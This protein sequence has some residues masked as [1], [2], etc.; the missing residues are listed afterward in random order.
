MLSNTES[1]QAVWHS[2]LNRLQ[3]GFYEA[4]SLNL[5]NGVNVSVDSPCALMIEFSDG[6]YK[7]YIQ[8]P[9]NEALE[10][11]VT[12]SGGITKTVKFSESVGE[13]GNDGGKTYRY[14][15]VLEKTDS[16]K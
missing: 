7:I 12:L 3:A 5:P 11:V 14:D 15:S 8:N 10:T 16:L 2:K 13:K 6:A 9:T 4:G 1:I